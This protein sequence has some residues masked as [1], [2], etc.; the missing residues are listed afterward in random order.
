MF[1]GSG[2]GSIAVKKEAY[3][4]SVICLYSL[5]LTSS[6]TSVIS[7]RKDSTSTCTVYA[8]ENTVNTLTDS[9]YN[10]DE[11]Y[12]ANSAAENAVMKFK[13]SSDVTINRRRND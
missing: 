5:D 7:V 3:N 11:N 10:N 12:S 13:D 4:P 6:F 9:A 1:A 2:N 8:V